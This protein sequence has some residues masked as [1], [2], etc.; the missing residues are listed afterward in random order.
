MQSGIYLITNNINDKVY[1]GQAK[2]FQKRW[3][4]KYNKH[5]TSAFKKHGKHNF[6]FHILEEVE[7][8]KDLLNL[9]EQWWLD[10][11]ESYDSEKGY[12]ICKEASSTLGYKHSEEDKE[13][14]SEIMKNK[15][16]QRGEN[17]GRAKLTWDDIYE[18]RKIY[19]E[20]NNESFKSLA[21][22]FNVS[23]GNIK[24]IIKNKTWKDI[25]Y[26]YAFKKRE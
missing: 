19:Y 14:M 21:Q 3:L 25:N 12:N 6:Y 11:F 23:D 17:N 15:D 4:K 9:R 24:F 8:D 10:W 20:N 13:K 1:V 5:L 16:H 18:I 22:K 7:L 2:D 26:I